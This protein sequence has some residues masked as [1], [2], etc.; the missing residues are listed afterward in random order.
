MQIV[1][2]L[3][4]L[5]EARAALTGSVGLVPARGALHAGKLSLVERAHAECAHVAV[6]LMGKEAPGH[7][8]LE[9][10]LRLLEPLGVD[11]VWAPTQAAVYPTGFQSWVMVEHVGLPLEGK[12]RPGHFQGFSTLM[13]KLFN[14]FSPRRAYFG[15]IDAQRA[16]II[17]RM[18]L[19]LDYSVDIVE[20]PTVREVDG[21][22][23]SSRNRLLSAQ[24]RPA[25]TVLYRALSSAHQAYAEGERDGDTL[26][27]I[28]SSTLASE[29]LA[30]EEYVSV[31]DPNSLA[32]LQQVAQGALLTMAARIGQVRLIDSL[33]LT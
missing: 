10:D 29:P 14:V 17:R 8:D 31:A 33:S 26:R 4:E 6:S 23:I 3:P 24:E 25:A 21:L 16:A 20:C 30:R 27:A 2:A 22:A 11:L 12:R 13:A 32:E 18:V 19:D 28:L 5:R 15:Q 9:R 7:D 1:T